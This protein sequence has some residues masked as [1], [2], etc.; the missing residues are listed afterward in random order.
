[1]KTGSSKYYKWRIVK[2]NYN[3][4]AEGETG[5]CYALQSRMHWDIFGGWY[6]VLWS[7]EKACEE[8]MKSSIEYDNRERIK[9][10]YT[11]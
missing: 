2:V 8:E 5:E 10:R 3:D 9:V 1:M 11:K 6:D 7:D 4:A